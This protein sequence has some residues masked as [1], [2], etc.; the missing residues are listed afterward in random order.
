[1]QAVG[2]YGLAV[3]LPNLVVLPLSVAV[4]EAFGFWWVFAM[5]AM[6]VLGIPAALLLDRSV[7]RPAPRQE[8]TESAVGRA[9][10]P[11]LML[12]V[13]TLAGGGLATF[14]PQVTGSSALS[15]AALAIFGLVSA[16]SRWGIG[17]VADR[18]GAHTLLAPMLGIA[19]AGLGLIA[20]GVEW[21]GASWVLVPA[22]AVLGLGYGSIQ[23]L[24][25]VAAFARV[26]R[27]GY[28]SASAVWNIGFDAG[29]G[30]GAVA[31]G[32]IASVS[33]FTVGFVAL[34]LAAVAAIPLTPGTR[35]ETF[36]QGGD[37]G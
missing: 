5:A 24:T 20:C 14:L 27:A 4:A 2:V 21:R 36:G 9:A 23:N 31:L 10:L 33:T 26:D 15:V 22:V 8:S 17:A 16:L 37:A 32:V 34:A 6:P 28:A 11:T 12:F 29:T 19:A 13:V 18:R 30:L 35:P 7:P 3:A 25:L 1:G